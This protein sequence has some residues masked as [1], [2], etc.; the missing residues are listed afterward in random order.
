M[1]IFFNTE[2]PENA[3]NMF[4]H[5]RKKPQNKTKKPDCHLLLFEGQIS[6]G[7]VLISIGINMMPDNEY[8]AFDSL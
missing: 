6:E 1:L 5:S 7:M 4:C 2:F 8:M 3:V